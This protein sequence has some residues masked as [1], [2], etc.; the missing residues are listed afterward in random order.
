MNALWLSLLGIAPLVSLSVPGIMAYVSIF[1]LSMLK[2]LI[3]LGTA[4]ATPRFGFW[5]IVIPAGSGAL[6]SVVLYTY[7]GTALNR[8]FRRTF[9]R[10]RQMS[11]SRRRKFYSIWKQYGLVG[12]SFLNVVISPMLSVGIAVS[13]QENPRKIIL[14]NGLSVIFWTFVAAAFREIIS[15]LV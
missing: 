1:F 11:F 7:F 12:I 10:K 3:A 4:A 14:W 15:G 13:F 5:E 8:W 6:V 2:F 9:K